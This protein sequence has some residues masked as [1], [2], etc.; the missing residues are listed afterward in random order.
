MLDAAI[1]AAGQIFTPPFRKVLWKTLALT[2]ALLA[3]AWLGFEKLIIAALALPI[4]APYPW[5]TMILT[6]IGGVG[7]FI[8]LAFLVTPVSFLVAGFFFDELAEHVEIELDPAGAG[9]AMPLGDAAWVAVR[10]AALALAVNLVALAL[11]FVPGVNAVAF[12]GANAYLFGRGYFELAALRHLPPPEVA[13]L[14]RANELQLFIAGLIMAGMLAVP[15]V[16][17]LTPLY[18]TAFMVRIADAIMLKRRG[19]FA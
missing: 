19:L 5:V 14:R 12:F 7:L 9:R 3:L 4:A 6:F 16:N 1:A 8:G 15:F 18:G 11:L 17:L 10:F 13:R 2:L